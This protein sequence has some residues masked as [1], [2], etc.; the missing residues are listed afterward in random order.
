MTRPLEWKD[1]AGE[2]PGAGSN[3]VAHTIRRVGDHEMRWEK[4]AAGPQLALP[5]SSYDRRS[6]AASAAQL[7]S[8]GTA[9]PSDSAQRDQSRTAPVIGTSTRPTHVAR[10]V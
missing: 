10:P 5:R 9:I 4:P 7:V 2:G 8:S 6:T 1:G 3:S